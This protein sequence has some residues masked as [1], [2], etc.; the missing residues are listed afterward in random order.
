MLTL[1]FQHNTTYAPITLDPRAGK[2]LASRS[3]KRQT[4][5]ID[6]IELEV[7]RDCDIDMYLSEFNIAD[8][9]YGSRL[10]DLKF[11]CFGRDEKALLYGSDGQS[12][13]DYIHVSL[14]RCD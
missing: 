1:Y 7:D 10:S 8:L 6:W 9:A 2:I 5:F 11:H 13:T 4:Q 3:V 12:D 14:M